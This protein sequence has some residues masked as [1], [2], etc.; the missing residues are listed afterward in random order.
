[1]RQAVSARW[2]NRRMNP[3]RAR[4]AGTRPPRLPRLHLPAGLDAAGFMRRYWQQRPLLIRGA[5]AAGPGACDALPL[6]P[7]A[8]FALAARD[9]VESRLVRG[10]GRNWSLAHGPFERLPLAARTPWTVLVQGVNLHAAAADRLLRCFDF[11]SA[12]RLD[13]LM[14]SYASD[15]GGVG[16][17][18]DS[19]DVFLI[20]IHGKR[21]WRI[22][23]NCPRTL[24][25][26]MP[27]KILAEF[28]AEQEWLLE[29]GDLLYLP[30][31]YAHEG[32]AVGP[33]M[34]ASVGFRAPGNAELASEF[35]HDLADRLELPG[36]YAD[37]KRPATAR[38][39]RLDDHLIDALA[40]NLARV[41]WRRADLTAFLLRHLSEPKPQ[42]F[43]EPPRRGL[44][45]VAWER[46]ARHAGLCLSAR[47]IMLYRGAI[48][49]INGEM[50]TAS[51]AAQAWL[52][53]LADRRVLTPADCAAALAVADLGPLLRE[54][55]AAGWVEWPAD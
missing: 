21:R 37:P 53:R 43:F 17:H 4:P 24:V 38:P 33:C 35:L 44:A 2:H 14:V 22:A 45:A 30:P 51:T 1:M 12:A 27:L 6:S 25:E 23:E 20:Q 47:S 36:R 26:G 16:P 39:A 32:T 55:H 52:R 29:P 42:V 5:F 19:Y 11:I 28:R 13:D 49:C 9:D 46:R 8:L 18:F 40:V 48:V 54:W 15:G 7:D 50:V 31:H 34:T 41:R 10:Q 3:S